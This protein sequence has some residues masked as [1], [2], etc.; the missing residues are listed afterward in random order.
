MEIQKDFPNSHALPKNLPAVSSFDYGFVQLTILAPRG[1]AN[2]NLSSSKRI[3]PVSC[4]VDLSTRIRHFIGSL[5]AS[6]KN[7]GLQRVLS[8]AK[9]FATSTGLS[10]A[11]NCAAQAGN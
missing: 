1:G 7:A 6:I 2:L 9:P 5:A 11:G 3:S 4:V 10:S 8:D